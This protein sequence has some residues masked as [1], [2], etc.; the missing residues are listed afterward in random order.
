[1][2]FNQYDRSKNEN[3]KF[4]DDGSGNPAIR[5]TAT[6][7]GDINIDSNSVNVSGIMGKASGTNADFT[8]AYSAAT[9]FTCSGLPSGV[10]K[11]AAD[12][13][14][15]IMQIATSGEVTE[16]YTRDDAT[17]T[18]SGTDPT[19]VTVTGASFVASDTFVVYTNIPQSRGDKMDL[20]E[21]GGT[22]V[23]TDGGVM[24]AGTQT[25]TLCDDD[26]AVKS[27]DTIEKSEAT[28]FSG[29]SV[30]RVQMYN[31]NG[32]IYMFHSLFG[33]DRLIGKT[34]D[35]N[36]D[37]TI[38]YTSATTLT[39]SNY[40]DEIPS[41]EVDDIVLIVQIDNTGLVTRVFFK[42][43]DTITM[44]GDVITISSPGTAFVAT[45]SF[46]LYTNPQF[47]DVLD[48]LVL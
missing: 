14:V 15:S 43:Q 1:M 17:M 2:A 3:L 22:T 11:I 8:T 31:E 16:T 45:D 10:T 35:T 33:A 20:I 26:P 18:C 7:S 6:I 42:D 21:I 4:V 24:D 36:A 41:M 48:C 5:T 46:V 39:V 25:V 23:N 28:T 29:T 32:A 47:L 44:S 9:K 40:S 19:T 27:L 12:D 37:F 13:I 38:A 30:K 34:N